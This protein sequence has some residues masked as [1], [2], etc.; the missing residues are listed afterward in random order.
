[1]Q[2]IFALSGVSK[3]RASRPESMSVCLF[4]CF[5]VS[6]K[7]VIDTALPPLPPRFLPGRAVDAKISP[8]LTLGADSNL[9]AGNMFRGPCTDPGGACPSIGE[10]ETARREFL[11]MDDIR[12]AYACG[13]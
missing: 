1:M 13:F 10:A 12:C 5:A 4:V 9:Q 7:S 8:V 6:Q 11:C 3:T 2:E